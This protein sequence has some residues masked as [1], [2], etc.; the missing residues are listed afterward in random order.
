MN[1]YIYTLSFLFSISVSAN[2]GHT[3]NPNT[4]YGGANNSAQQQPQNTNSQNQPSQNNIVN[5]MNQSAEKVDKLGEATEML[6]TT[7][8]TVGASGLASCYF[9]GGGSAAQGKEVLEGVSQGETAK[10]G[11]GNCYATWGLVTVAGIGLQLNGKDAKKQANKLSNQACE[12]DQSCN[13][14]PGGTN[15][16]GGPS[17]LPQNTDINDDISN[18]MSQLPPNLGLSYDPET[19]N[20]KTPSGDVPLSAAMNGSALNQAMSMM[21]VEDSKKISKIK[22]KLNEIEE[23]AKVVT[24][25]FNSGGGGASGSRGSNTVYEED[26]SLDKLLAQ[27]RNRNRKGSPSAVAAGKVSTYNGG[28]IG[29]KMDNIFDMIHRA[30]DKYT[31]MGYFY[32]P[33]TRL[34]PDGLPARTGK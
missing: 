15:A 14:S 8:T 3:Y 5:D 34:G 6:G 10:S 13:S 12:I 28:P 29:H 18:I 25:G 26:D 9:T 17:G 4:K 1:K 2:N 19:E 22:R 30:Y 27:M 11:N 16:L 24:M 20:F 7:A 32:P 23:Q 33:G 21:S 31:E